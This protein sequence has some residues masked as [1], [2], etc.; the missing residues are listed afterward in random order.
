MKN[1]IINFLEDVGVVSLYL[2]NSAVKNAFHN[3]WEK[4][5][6]I[7]QDYDIKYKLY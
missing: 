4:I 5:Y 6:Y 7:E 3:L 1:R 2:V